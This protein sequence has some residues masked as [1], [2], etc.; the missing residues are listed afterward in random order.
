MRTVEVLGFVDDAVFAS[1]SD[2]LACHWVER[3]VEVAPLLSLTG[4]RT[5]PRVYWF[6]FL[7]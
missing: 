6:A 2:P 3:L 7:W 4:T 5:T 1:S